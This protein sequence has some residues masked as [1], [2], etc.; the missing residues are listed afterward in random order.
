MPYQPLPGFSL[1]VVAL[2]LFGDALAIGALGGSR[3]EA[4]G[5]PARRD[6]RPGQIESEQGPP[7]ISPDWT[8]PS[9]VLGDGGCGPM[10]RSFPRTCSRS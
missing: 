9:L 5:A 4:I 1:E 3:R 7:G 10:H 8:L 2:I 6:G